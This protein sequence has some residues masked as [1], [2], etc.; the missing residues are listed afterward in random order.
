M[1]TFKLSNILTLVGKIIS[2]I[3]QSKVDISIKFNRTQPTCQLLAIDGN[4]VSHF[5]FFIPL[6]ESG[7]YSLH[8]AQHICFQLIFKL[9]DHNH[10][11]NDQAYTFSLHFFNN[12]RS[13]YL[14]YLQC[15]LHTLDT[16]EQSRVIH[17][18][19]V[20][21]IEYA[22]DPL[23]HHLWL[24]NPHIYTYDTHSVGVKIFYKHILKAISNANPSVNFSV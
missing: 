8:N 2:E 17:T 6:T 12:R 23:G 4:G 20:K 21:Y 11:D 15:Q 14:Y 9:R 5:D 19:D 10:I 16:L 13:D 3:D 18:T 24:L 1:T 22:Q 7:E